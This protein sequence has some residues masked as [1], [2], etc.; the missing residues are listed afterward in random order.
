MNPNYIDKTKL[1]SPNHS[2]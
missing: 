1:F 2:N